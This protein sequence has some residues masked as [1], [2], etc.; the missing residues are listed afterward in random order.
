VALIEGTPRND[1]ADQK[2]KKKKQSAR[3]ATTLAAVLSA[4]CTGFLALNS[5]GVAFGLG[6]LSTGVIAQF[7]D[8]PLVRVPLLSFATIGAL[9]VL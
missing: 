7:F 1:N 9:V 3:F 5:A 4:P 2:A 8:Q 6:T